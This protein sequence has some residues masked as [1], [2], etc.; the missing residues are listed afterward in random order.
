M[1]HHRQAQEMQNIDQKE[2]SFW[3]PICN[4]E[5]K[6]KEITCVMAKIF[7]LF[8]AFSSTAFYPAWS[9]P[10]TYTHVMDTEHDLDSMQVRKLDSLYE[11]HEDHTTNEIAL[12]TTA[13]YYPDS[14]ISSYSTKKL[15]ELGLGLRDI[16][17]GL[18][19]VF[20]RANKEVRIG[21]GKGTEKVLTNKIARHIIDSIMIPAFKSDSIYKGLWLGSKAIVDFLEIRANKIK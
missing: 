21:T 10:K 4:L 6:S 19:I 7:L 8:L 17:N 9:G 13:T 1:S 11:N 18:I 12:I 3:H 14:N 16:N 20:S 2:H 15:N 5:G